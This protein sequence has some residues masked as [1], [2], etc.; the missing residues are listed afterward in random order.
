MIISV[1]HAYSTELIY[2]KN[3]VDSRSRLDI[4]SVLEPAI[5]IVVASSLVL[6]PVLLGCYLAIRTN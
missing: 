3:W 6:G 1:M 4:Y 2:Y 5:S